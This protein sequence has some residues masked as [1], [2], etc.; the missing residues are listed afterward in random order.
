MNSLHISLKKNQELI[1]RKLILLFTCLLGLAEAKA[2]EELIHT[3]A[4]I[5]DQEISGIEKSY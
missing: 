2:V 5:I 3:Q 1:M 4:E